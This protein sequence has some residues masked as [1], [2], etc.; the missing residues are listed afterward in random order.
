MLVAEMASADVVHLYVIRFLQIFLLINIVG[1]GF[2]FL[3]R[4]IYFIIPASIYIIFGVF[5]FSESEVSGGLFSIIWWFL[6]MSIMN[7]SIANQADF[8]HFKKVLFKSTFLLTCLTACLGLYK[9]FEMSRGNILPFTEVLRYDG[10]PTT[11]SGSSLNIDYNVYSIGLFCGLFAGVYCYKNTIKLKFKL[12]YSVSIL[13]ILT[14]AMLSS[15]R[16]GLIIGVFVI[17][18]L[19]IWSFKSNSWR[20]IAE[21][22]HR[23][24]TRYVRAPWIVIILMVALGIFMLKVNPSKLVESSAEI[25]SLVDRLETVNSLTSKENDTRG[26]RWEYAFEYYSDLPIYAQIFGDGFSYLKA[27]GKEFGETE[28][29]H[30]HNV[31]IASL[32]YGGIVGFLFTVWLTIY[33]LYIYFKKR[34]IYAE[35]IYWY[36]LFLML[37]FTSSNSIYSSRLFVVL[38]L[39]PFL[40]FAYH[41][42]SQKA[43]LPN[44]ENN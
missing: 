37:N 42:L 33:V 43:W 14:S 29:D 24:P 40:N 34:E 23:I 41:N 18:F 25:T 5:Y 12:L 30:P 17:V 6:F 39:F 13:L 8:N 19:V 3:N 10:T 35:I 1:L 38:L 11:L 4:S 22:R 26:N 36:V 21:L 7:Y 15:S 20:R 32:L 27:F 9:L 44:F 16:R 2:K 28:L 31:W